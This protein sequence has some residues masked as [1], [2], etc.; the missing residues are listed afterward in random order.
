[1]TAKG[2][3]LFKISPNLY[4]SQAIL[5]VYY[6]DIYDGSRLGQIILSHVNAQA[7]HDQISRPVAVEKANTLILESVGWLV[8]DGYK[9]I[10]LSLFF[11][12]NSELLSKIK[13][14]LNISSY[15]LT[16]VKWTLVLKEFNN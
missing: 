11:Q 7:T 9:V 10:P 12:Q 5:L 14:G 16:N 2:V 6:G 8:Q 1:M 4:L 3:I 15:N 13:F